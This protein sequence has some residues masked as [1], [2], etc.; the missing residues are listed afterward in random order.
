MPVTVAMY[1]NAFEEVGEQLN[2][3]GLDITVHTFG[4][5]G[6]FLIDGVSV[7]PGEVEVDYLWLSQHIYNGDFKDGAFDTV[8]ACK[9]VGVLQTFN[10]GL[11][12]PLYKAMSKRGTRII[13]S[14][15][16]AVA[17]SEF[18]MAHVLSLIHPIDLQREQ[19]ATK[20]WE[21]TPFRE[22]SRMN[23]LIV[24]YG[25]IG[26][27]L[28]KRVKSFGS[29]ITVI[30]R[31]PQT[32]ELVDEAGTMDDLQRFLPNADVIVL[33]CPLNNE[34]R[35]F[36][37]QEFFS[38]IKKGALLVNIARGPLIDDAAMLSALDSGQLANA[39]LDVFH[40]EPL[41]ESDP[42]WSHPKVRLTPHTSFAGNGARG[43]WMQLFLAGIT[44]FVNGEALANEVNP[45]DI[46]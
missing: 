9:S 15:A 24:G 28:S 46:V 25:P 43:R 14:S 36:A 40:T 7:A 13:N 22:L 12:D 35:G 30:R 41:P 16:Q 8:L 5:D 32:S 19:Q 17:I 45:R 31:S 44:R 3:L 29:S 26:Q 39:V 38:A 23:W 2:A 6:K 42:L 10:A 4:R 1:D 11:D 20:H 18:V 33:A 27:E 34:T 37:G 21:T